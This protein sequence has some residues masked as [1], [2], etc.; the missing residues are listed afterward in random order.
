MRFQ[1]SG[2]RRQCWKV[3]E[4]Y[5]SCCHALVLE[6]THKVRAR[7]GVN[8][9]ISS[10]LIP[11]DVCH[12]SAFASATRVMSNQYYTYFEITICFWE[13]GKRLVELGSEMRCCL[14]S[15]MKRDSGQC[16]IPVTSALLPFL[17][18][19]SVMHNLSLIVPKIQSSLVSCQV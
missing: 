9:G 3:V 6:V 18:T 1:S 8:A 13:R 15:C 19:L 5:H 10:T 7:H 17:Y 4:C 12:M 2:R 14:F 16:I 11:L